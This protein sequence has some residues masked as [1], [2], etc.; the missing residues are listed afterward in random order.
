MIEFS[1][2]EARRVYLISDLHLGHANIIRYC[3]RPFR[4]VGEM[5]RT[6]IRN[7]NA[8]VEPE[9]TVF[10]L[11]DLCFGRDSGT[12]ESWLKRLAGQI[13]FIRGSHDNGIP[14]DST[15]LYEIVSVGS[16]LLYLVHNA[17]DAPQDWDGWIVHGHNHNKR[18]FIDGKRINVSAEVIGYRPISLAAIIDCAGRY[19]GCY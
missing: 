14:E 7:W 13:V 1:I 12:P 16:L 2:E 5:N 8:V 15:F 9:N 17:Y 10:F 18:P 11:G 6:L 19:C 3:N 4:N